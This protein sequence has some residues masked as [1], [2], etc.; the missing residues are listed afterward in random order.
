MPTI[1][2]IDAKTALAH[3]RSTLRLQPPESAETG[4]PTTGESLTSDAMLLQLAAATARRL[5]GFMCP[6][7]PRDVALAVERSLTRLPGMQLRAGALA[8]DA[9][10]DLLSAGDVLESEQV[11]FEGA[12]PQSRWLFCAPPSFIPRGERIYITGIAP[13]DAPFLPLALRDRVICEGGT[14]YI[15][16]AG[17][18]ATLEAALTS[19]GL[20]KLDPQRWLTSSRIVQASSLV[21]DLRHRLAQ[22]GS[23]GH[24]E[25]VTIVNRRGPG[26][27]TYRSR[28]ST[29]KD[30]SGLFVARMPKLYGAPLWLVIEA[31]KGVIRRSMLLPS[32]GSRARAC[33]E[34]WRLQL[35]L[36]AGDGHA[37]SYRV[38]ADDMGA[39]LHL[40]FPIP[41]EARRRLILIGAK[42][43]NDDAYLSFW[44]PQ[45]QLET[46]ERYLQQHLWFKRVDTFKETQ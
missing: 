1:K 41:F 9:V 6:C 7:A 34:A 29:L 43:R 14:R 24:L 5:C 17:D 40:D 23:K 11:T 21:S 18:D 26:R 30:E 8:A 12:D 16:L 2:V 45:S 38:Q 13:D 46:E 39:T 36:D 37:A 22:S 3:A 20:R 33:D 35:A 10:D 32:R 44:V 15:S 42:R 19:L 27:V 28:W 4:K 25:D 31:D